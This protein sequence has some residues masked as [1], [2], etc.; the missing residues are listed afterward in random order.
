MDT[1]KRRIALPALLALALAC[2]GGKTNYVEPQLT[3]VDPAQA[4]VGATV[5]ISGSSFKGTNAVSFAGAPA[6]WYQV[7]GGAQIVA[8]VPPD[9]ATGS[10]TVQNPAGV[11]TSTFVFT[12]QPQITSIEPP[13]GP[14][15]SD[16]ATT[17]TLTITGYGLATTTAVAVGG[18]AI[19]PQNITVYDPHT[20]KV[21]VMGS[22]ITGGAVTVTASGLEATGPVF[23]VTP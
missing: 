19:D 1:R 20:L 4:A 10:I 21:Q 18:V 5:A 15:T 22:G 17:T 2:G 8:I 16:V 14:V 11:R 13:T 12:V 7:N 23:T 6:T 3:S 9:A